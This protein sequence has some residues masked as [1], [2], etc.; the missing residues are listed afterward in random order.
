M[1]Y[2]PRD[3]YDEFTPLRLL[4]RR[5]NRSYN[6]AKRGDIH[7]GKGPL[8]AS[9]PYNRRKIKSSQ[10]R[11]KSQV[12]KLDYSGA[13]NNPC[14]RLAH[15]TDT[16]LASRT[17][18][19]VNLVDINRIGVSHTLNSRIRDVVQ[20]KGFKINMAFRG[21]NAN[22]TYVNWAV[23]A[24]RNASIPNLTNFFRGDG[25]GDRGADFG[26]SRT[27]LENHTMDINSDDYVVLAKD[28]AVI[29]GSGSVELSD[30]VVFERYIPCNTQV[31]YD[32]SGSAH[33]N[34]FL[35][36]WNDA[37]Y[38]NRDSTPITSMVDLQYRTE[39]FFKDPI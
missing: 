36:Y 31:R 7:G 39:T 16:V 5:L 32:S 33:Q 11:S 13:L 14:K 10:R 23:I 28:K 18:A 17:L 8:S 26:I 21:L 38:A 15:T 1:P 30:I 6:Y 9:S 22:N 12:A 34:I 4:S 25:G 29:S 19:F 27:P 2:P 35:I 3:Q 37:C 20:L 24:M